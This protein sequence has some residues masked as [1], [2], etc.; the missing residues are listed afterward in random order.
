MVRA[1]AAVVASF[2]LG[3]AALTFLGG[4]LGVMAEPVALW[5]MGVTLV[6]GSQA[7]QPRTAATP[8]QA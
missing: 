6:V 5:L 7:L 2:G 3:S 8:A 1:V 4:V